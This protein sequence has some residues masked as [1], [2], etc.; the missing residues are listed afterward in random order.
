[1]SATHNGS[2]RSI[3]PN[4][5]RPSN[6]TMRRAAAIS[7]LYKAAKV[8][9]DGSS[10]KPETAASTTELRWQVNKKQCSQY[11]CEVTASTRAA[12]LAAGWQRAHDLGLTISNTVASKSVRT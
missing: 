6:K 8:L 11:L 2:R 12:N 4:R 9:L 10:C 3:R 5:H 1:M 7:A